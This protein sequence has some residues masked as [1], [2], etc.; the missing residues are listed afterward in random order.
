MKE[1][2][3]KRLLT[4]WFCLYEIINTRKGRTSDR[5]QISCFQGLRIEEGINIVHKETFW[6]DK[7][8]LYLDSYEYTTIYIDKT[9]QTTLKIG[10]FYYIL[11]IYQ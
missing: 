1:A 5:K 11:I 10:E 8:V 6:G 4:V 9:H 7:N 3:N 2:R